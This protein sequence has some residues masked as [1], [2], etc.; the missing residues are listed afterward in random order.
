MRLGLASYSS[1]DYYLTNRAESR[2]TIHTEALGPRRARFAAELLPA[3][4]ALMRGDRG[5]QPS[6]RPDR[7]HNWSKSPV[8]HIGHV[9][10]PRGLATWAAWRCGRRGP[11]ARSRPEPSETERPG[12][13]VGDPASDG[14]LP[15]LT[16]RPTPEHSLACPAGVAL[17]GERR[18]RTLA[19]P[20]TANGG[21]R[22]HAAAR[23]HR[24]AVGRRCRRSGRAVL[25]RARAH[26]RTGRAGP[27]IRRRAA[28]AAR[29]R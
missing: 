12:P 21:A 3:A 7:G 2:S 26:R 27:P 10:W 6:S 17:T 23:R 29:V 14:T 13:S 22:S 11:T 4:E 15:L 25:R 18:P 19:G 1:G 5:P 9:V 16:D 8:A 20:D 24:S 28:R